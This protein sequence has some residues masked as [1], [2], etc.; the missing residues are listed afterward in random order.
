MCISRVSSFLLLFLGLTACVEPITFD[1]EEA[2]SYLVVDGLILP[3]TSPLSVRLTRSSAFGTFRQ[4]VTGAQLMLYDEAGQYECYEEVETEPGLYHLQPALITVETGS[5]YFIEIILK[6]E[7]VYRSMLEIVPPLLS[8]D[9]L[10]YDI[11]TEVVTDPTGAVQER[12]FINMYVHSP[13]PSTSEAVYLR[14]QVSEAYSFMDLTCH[15]LDNSETCYFDKG[16]SEPQNLLLFSNEDTDAHYLT[17]FPLIS[18]VLFPTLEY[19]GRHYF[20]VHQYAITQQAFQYWKDV[21]QVLSIGGTL[22]DPPPAGIQGNI[23]N[24][25]DDSELVLGYVGAASVDT[26][27]FF[28]L[29]TDIR[30]YF[31]FRD[32]CLGKT[33]GAPHGDDP[34]GCCFCN[35]LEVNDQPIARPAYWGQ[36]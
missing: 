14:W 33:F 7:S 27:R 26:I 20:N 25:A 28:T 9:S 5:G 6:D 3:G 21:E 1:Q 31:N 18:Q 32:F 4:P 36:D 15:P 13:L 10:S 30:P 11:T 24:T 8:P 17:K 29:P 22:F 23:Y 19:E 35:L 16:I 2:A 34:V 12:N